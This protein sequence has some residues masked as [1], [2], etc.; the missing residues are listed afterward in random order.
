MITLSMIV[1][2]EEKHL[3]NC[4]ESV[5]KVV[6]EIVLV[7]TGSTDNTLEIAKKYSAKIF[8][9]EWINDFAAARN[10]ALEKSFGDW[11]L[12]LDADECLSQKSVYELQK[13]TKNKKREAFKCIINNIDEINSRPSVMTYTRLFPNDKRVRFEGK[14]HEQIENS[15]RKNNY[16]IKNSRIEIDHYGYNLTKD[17]LRNK[18]KRNLSILLKQFDEIKSSYYAFHLGQTYAVLNE[19]ENAVKYF[20]TSLLDPKLEKES[21]SLAYRYLAIDNAGQQ[22]Y[23]AAS[24]LIDK[25]LQCDNEQPLALFAAANI[26]L[27][28]GD[29]N[30][31]EKYSRKAFEVNRKYLRGEKTSNQ[32]ILIDELQLCYYGL[33]I[34]LLSNNT[35]LFNFFYKEYSLL[36]KTSGSIEL[37]LFEKLLNNQP[38]PPDRLQ[39]Y[40]KHITTS[41]IALVL[42]LFDRYNDKFVKLTLLQLSKEKF[43]ENSTFYN[44]LGMLLMES[45]KYAEAANTFEQSIII[46]N[47]DP[48]TV[49]YLVSAYLQNGEPAKIPAV[50]YSAEQKFANQEQVLSRLTLLREKLPQIFF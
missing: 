20:T 24:E 32:N 18:A 8:H 4:L 27:K 33:E 5:K 16:V 46:N 44:K 43:S 17:D 37:E 15:L 22:N 40:A 25:S 34:A 38:I 45:Q 23:K 12:Y 19:K 9:F 13:L 3:A 35:E 41:N 6:D 28:L 7:D 47:D 31:A 39:N 36:N 48:S 26:Y 42:A 50:V 2:N 30:V 1:K 10:F 11:I 49:F 29:A 14:V 21:R